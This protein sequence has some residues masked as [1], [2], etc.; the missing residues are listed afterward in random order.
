MQNYVGLSGRCNLALL[1]KREEHCQENAGKGYQVVPLQT[2]ALKHHRS[3]DRKDYQRDSLLNYL[4]LHEREWAAVFAKTNA[5][6]WHLAH[7]FCQRD[8]PRQQYHAD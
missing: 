6:G 3:K 4:E 2:L 5:V 8:E 1:Q 7:I